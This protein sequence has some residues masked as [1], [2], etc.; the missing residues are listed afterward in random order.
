MAFGAFVACELATLT[1]L[2]LSVLHQGVGIPGA[3]GLGWVGGRGILGI[4]GGLLLLDEM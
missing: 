4:Q 3:S 1:F 2:A